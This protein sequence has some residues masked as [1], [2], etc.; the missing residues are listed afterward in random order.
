VWPNRT[1]IVELTIERFGADGVV[2]RRKNMTSHQ[3]GLT[4]VYTG[5]IHGNQIDGEA[6]W[7]WDGFK[8]GVVHGPWHAYIAGAPDAT[9]MAQYQKDVCE[10]IRRQAWDDLATEFAFWLAA[11]AAAGSPESDDKNVA[12]WMHA[13]VYNGPERRAHPR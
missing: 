1:T 3:W 13:A 8:G 11:G 9:I 6:D 2:I 7:I 12:A 10:A 4:A 5:T